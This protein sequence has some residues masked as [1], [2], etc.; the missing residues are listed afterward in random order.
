MVSE[1]CG[2]K[3]TDYTVHLYG[4]NVIECRPSGLKKCH[5]SLSS[6]SFV[7]SEG[8][9]EGVIPAFVDDDGLLLVASAKSTTR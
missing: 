1:I 6:L 2:D 9:L 4:L 7:V 3:V 5:I 8:A